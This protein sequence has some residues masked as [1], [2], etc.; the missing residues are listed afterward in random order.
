MT[1]TRADKRSVFAVYI[2]ELPALVEPTPEATSPEVR[3]LLDWLQTRG[4]STICYRDIYRHLAGEK[5]SA[6]KL[7]ETLEKR[8]WLIPLR[9]HRYDRKCWQVTI[10]PA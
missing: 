5:E 4:K 10:G 9:S 1:A 7:A 3:R 6:L 8:G 2:E